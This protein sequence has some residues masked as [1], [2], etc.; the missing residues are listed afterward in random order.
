MKYKTC[1]DL[2]SA[3]L[4]RMNTNPYAGKEASQWF[5]NDPET[6]EAVSLWRKYNSAI[7][8]PPEGVVGVGRITYAEGVLME[9]QK[10]APILV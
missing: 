10:D 1:D 4:D 7:K 6:Q 5:E 8:N 9:A 3:L 2:M